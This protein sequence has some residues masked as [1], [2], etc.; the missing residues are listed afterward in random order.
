MGVLP[1]TNR[2]RGDVKY[3]KPMVQRFGSLREHTLGLGPS[4]GGDAAS[5][6]HRS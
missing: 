4:S 1:E 2:P 3:E 5:I 6:Y